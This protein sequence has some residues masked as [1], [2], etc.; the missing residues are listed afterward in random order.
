MRRIV[1]N[2]SIYLSSIPNLITAYHKYPFSI[3]ARGPTHALT[4]A[5]YLKSTELI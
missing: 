5:V 3:E 4:N 2:V 1:R